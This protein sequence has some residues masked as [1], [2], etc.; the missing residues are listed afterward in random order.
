VSRSAGARQ[1]EPSKSQGAETIPETHLRP[2]VPADLRQEDAFG[3]GDYAAAAVDTLLEAEAPFTLGVFGDWG[4]GKTTIIRAIGDRV[5]AAGSAFVIF[6]VWRYEDD[7]LRRQFLREVAQQLR[8]T[9]QLRRWGWRK[10]WRSYKPER[11]LRDLEVDVPVPE[12]RFRLSLRGLLAAFLHFVV[13]FVP[14]WLFL[15]SSLPSHIW[16]HVRPSATSAEEVAVI[17]AGIGFLYSVVSQIFRVDQR[18]VTVRRIEEPERFEGKFRE[19]LELTRSQ[20]V[21]IAIDNLDRCSAGLV[22]KFLATIKTY[23]EPVA[24][25]SMRPSDEAV[26]S[27]DRPDRS[28]AQDRSEAVFVIAADEAAVRRHMTARELAALQPLSPALSGTDQERREQERQ[29]LRDA[30][31]QVDEYLRKFFNATIRVRPLLPEDVKSFAR[32]QL[33][34]FFTQHMSP[35]AA[36]IV[37]VSHAAERTTHEEGD[38]IEE[39]R[40]RLVTM[41]AG[42]LRKN[43]R[44]IKQFVRNLDARLKTI[45]ERERNGRIVPKISD[46]IL[47]IAKVVIIEEEWRDDYDA[48]ERD[49]RKLAEWQKQAVDLEG[50]LDNSELRI[51]LQFNRDIRPRNV[52]AIVN[53]K[54]ESDD[55]VLPDFGDFRDAI[56]Y[57]D[58]S[59]AE[60]IVV[61]APEEIRSEYSAR[62]P[63]LLA[64]ELRAGGF[65]E[66]R[67]VLDAALRDP[68]LGI[69]DSRIRER[70]L[71]DAAAQPPVVGQ[72][73]T[74]DPERFFATLDGLSD[75]ER[76]K[77]RAPF[78]N[79]GS[80]ASYGTDVVQRACSQLAPRIGELDE[81]ERA[82]I[83]NVIAVDPLSAQLRASYLPL[84]EA[85]SSLLTDT[86]LSNAFQGLP[87]GIMSVTSPEFRLLT[88]GFAAGLGGQLADQFLERLRDDFAN[89]GSDQTQVLAASEPI[90]EALEKFGT[91]SDAALANLLNGMRG[92]LGVV[93]GLSDG[94]GVTVLLNVAGLGERLDQSA[95]ASAIGEADQIARDLAASFPLPLAQLL[96]DQRPDV[97]PRVRDVITPPLASQLQAADPTSEDWSTYASALIELDREAGLMAGR[98]ELLRRCGLGQATEASV[99][100]AHVLSGPYGLAFA[101]LLRSGEGASLI[102]QMGVDLRNRLLTDLQVR[103][104]ESNLVGAGRFL[105][106]SLSE[107][108]GSE[109]VQF[110]AVIVGWIDGAPEAIQEIEE[111]IGS[112]QARVIERTPVV[113][114]LLRAARKPTTAALRSQAILFAAQIAD[115]STPLNQLCQEAVV[116][117]EASDAELDLET[118]R[119]VRAGMDA[120]W[121]SEVR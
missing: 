119:L 82:G 15:R 34:N 2:D 20:R 110:R 4:I 9:N 88:L 13:I 80:L 26:S 53:L 14:L 104:F 57:G 33:G 28:S 51:F 101:Q 52:Q 105:S 115:G 70:M 98:D 112:F 40:E 71:S 78:V 72:F 42:A 84:V 111:S 18:F 7:A 31:Y 87:A 68:P 75:E 25:Q 56:A 5:R 59:S 113:R 38:P 79:L 24:E 63:E 93:G 97:G 11:E 85:D 76:R 64:R 21:V 66:A 73:P 114:A 10:H 48:L 37:T 100:A 108:T 43:P 120:G 89:A 67:N 61:G 44:R 47:G 16:G 69:A 121:S 65:V 46:D 107:L 3:H 54:L 41:V 62:L 45:K 81:V 36:P 1:K 30:E 102:E 55:L 95:Y 83:R 49:H 60:K 96:V 118:A 91:G 116:T 35:Q 86:A 8:E 117:L 39:D 106:D 99:A 29:Q 32:D 94:R 77:G 50:N 12:E 19:L 103:A 109:R 90:T 74:L 6:D 92:S 27:K 58:L 23:L 22:D 17:I